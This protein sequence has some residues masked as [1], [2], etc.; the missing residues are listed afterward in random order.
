[1][2]DDNILECSDWRPKASDEKSSE[3][4]TSGKMDLN[5]SLDAARIGKQLVTLTQA[6]Q[7]SP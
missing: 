2:V 5:Q 6:K 3:N 1:M 7:D 4:M